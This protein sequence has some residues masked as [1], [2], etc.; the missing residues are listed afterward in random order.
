MYFDPLPGAFMM[1][2]IPENS[3]YQPLS[4]DTRMASVIASRIWVK[5]MQAHLDS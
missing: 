1:L 5:L 4:Q 2:R 3:L